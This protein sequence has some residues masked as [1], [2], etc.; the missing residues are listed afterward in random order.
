VGFTARGFLRSTFSTVGVSYNRAHS[1]ITKNW[2]Y[3]R[4][5]RSTS[6]SRGIRIYSP[7]SHQQIQQLRRIQQ[8]TPHLS[9]RGL[10]QK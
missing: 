8:K 2:I 10:S 4:G 3:T 7:A 5:A 9:I 6:T 1:N